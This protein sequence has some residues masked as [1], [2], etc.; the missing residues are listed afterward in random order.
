MLTSGP[1]T[2]SWHQGTL[3]HFNSSGPLD[4]HTFTHRSRMFAFQDYIWK[5][6]LNVSARLKRD[7]DL[8][9]AVS[10]VFLLIYLTYSSRG[11]VPFGLM[12]PT[13]SVYLFIIRKVNQTLKSTSSVI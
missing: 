1:G 11:T 9:T 10:L 6:L 4:T 7:N 5:I 2:G 3:N 8:Y 12:A 13:H